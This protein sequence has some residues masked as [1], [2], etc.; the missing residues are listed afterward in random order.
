MNGEL[1]T[2][3]RTLVFSDG[4]AIRDVPN[5]TYKSCTEARDLWA[6]QVSDLGYM[7]RHYSAI[8]TPQGYA[9]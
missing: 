1:Y 5:L 6:K 8:C 9:R 7:G 4:V 3:I 2:L